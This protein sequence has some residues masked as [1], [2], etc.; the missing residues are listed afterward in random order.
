MSGHHAD[1]GAGYS[2]PSYLRSFAADR[3]KINMS[4]IRGIGTSLAD[5]TIIRAILALARNLRFE[6]VA[7]GVERAEQLRSLVGAGHETV[8]GYYF[9]APQAAADIPAYAA[10]LTTRFKS[11]PS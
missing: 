1:F 8:Q 6:V 7:E 4:F 3:I 5:E 2:N 10:S 9:A 11:T